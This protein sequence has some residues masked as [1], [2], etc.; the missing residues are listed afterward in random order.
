MYVS[1]VSVSNIPAMT[2]VIEQFDIDLNDRK[3]IT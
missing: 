3:A 2:A 1:A